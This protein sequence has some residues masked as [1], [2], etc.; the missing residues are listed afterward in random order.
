[1]RIHLFQPKVYAMEASAEIVQKNGK[2][3]WL[4][5][6]QVAKSHRTEDWSWWPRVRRI[7][8]TVRGREHEIILQAYTMHSLGGKVQ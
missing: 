1:M 5:K 7:L 4:L 6:V 2:S 3:L 8:V